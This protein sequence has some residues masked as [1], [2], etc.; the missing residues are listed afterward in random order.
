VKAE[1]LEL[2]KAKN[3]ELFNFMKETR[4]R[5]KKIV[6]NYKKVA[7]ALLKKNSPGI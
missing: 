3:A 5:R 7:A 6:D 1:H 4:K 2:S